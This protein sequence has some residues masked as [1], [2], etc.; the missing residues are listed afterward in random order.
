SAGVVLTSYAIYTC[1][2]IHI[3][4]TCRCI[5]A[6]FIAQGDIAVPGSVHQR[7]KSDSGVVFT[8]NVCL[9]RS[10]TD[11]GIAAA[12][13]IVL[14][15][16][17]TDTRVKFTMRIGEER[18]RTDSGVDVPVDVPRECRPAD[19]RVGTPGSVVL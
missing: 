19:G 8:S 10:L 13:R 1:S 11:G 17:T 4:R 18:P 9:E 12:S 16:T 14:E 15:R 2:D 7:F 3:I 5:V 6:G